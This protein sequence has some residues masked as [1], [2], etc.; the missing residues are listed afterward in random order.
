VVGQGPKFDPLGLLKTLESHRVTYIVIGGFARIVQGAEELT[1]GLDVVPRMRTEEGL[2]RLG[3]AL[4]ELEARR[5]DGKRFSFDQETLV[6]EPLL[7]LLT[8]KGE[9]KLVVQP[10]GTG[11]YDDLR[12]AS[13]REYLGKGI[14]AEIAS[15]ADLGRMLAALGREQDAGKLFELRRLIELERGMGVGLSL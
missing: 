1:Y 2:R 12:R 4:G 10:E 11:G 9:L 3:L 6:R 8:A 7:E 5:A 14:R 13:R 15:P